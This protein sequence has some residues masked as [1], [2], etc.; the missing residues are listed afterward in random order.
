MAA[1]PGLAASVTGNNFVDGCSDIGGSDRFGC[2]AEREAVTP[3]EGVQLRM[4]QDDPTRTLSASDASSTSDDT[5]GQVTWSVEVPDAAQPGKAF[6]E[7]DYS[8]PTEIV[9]LAAG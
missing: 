7:T 4:R 9:I 8:E 6:L 2:E 5:L 1:Q 3:I